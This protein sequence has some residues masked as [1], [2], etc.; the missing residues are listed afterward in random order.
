[1]SEVRTITIKRGLTRLKTIKAQLG[2][3][4]SKIAQYGAGS[5]KEKFALVESRG[6]RKKNHEEARKEIT[7]LYQQFDDLTN[8]Y[9]KIKRAI[10]KANLEKEIVIGDKVMTIDDALTY[11]RHIQDYVQ[12]L[13]NSYN[14]A[15]NNAQ[16]KVERANVGIDVSKLSA[17]EQEE[18][19]ASVVYNVD[20]KLIEEKNKFLVEFLTELDGLIDE[21][22]VLTHIEISED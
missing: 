11:Q 17:S 16:N 19:L 13:V 7:S 8:E 6:T 15:V 3:I 9:S 20:P 21:A 2:D 22:N 14:R 18:E 1:M 10:N 12:S 4:S 5:S